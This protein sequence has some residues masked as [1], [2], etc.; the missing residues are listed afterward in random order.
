MQSLLFMWAV[1]LDWKYIGMGF[2]VER[3]QLSAD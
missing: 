3:S 2:T 1:Y